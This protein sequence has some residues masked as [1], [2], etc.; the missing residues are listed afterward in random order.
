MLTSY[1][2]VKAKYITGN[3]ADAFDGEGARRYGGRWNTV[4]TAMVYTSESAAL[5]AL[6]MLVHLDDASLLP[7][8]VVCP[9][10]FDASLVT[11]LDPAT[12]PTDWK[13]TPAPP[14]LAA[15]GD[16]WVQSGASLLLRVPSAVLP[17][18]HNFLINPRHADFSRLHFE[19]L[20]AFEFDPR[21][22]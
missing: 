16:A 13:Q 20:Q 22:F 5:A 7:R 2:I 14:S 9:V 8:Y 18:E 4:G 10:R 15:I 12:L 3:I 19:P 6:E 11:D 1:R 17:L 21:L